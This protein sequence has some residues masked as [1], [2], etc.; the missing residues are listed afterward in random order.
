MYGDDRLGLIQQA[1]T[2]LLENLADNDY[3]SIVTYAGDCRVALDGAV[4]HG[5]TKIANVLQDL[6][7]SGSTNGSGGIQLAYE[8]AT[9]YFVEGATT[10]LFLPPT[11]TS[12]WAFP[13]KTNSNPSFPKNATAAFI[14]PCW[15]W[16]C[17][18]PTTPQ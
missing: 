9:K 15:G 12:T 8:E 13:T 3:V 10:E 6:E 5:K 4:R 2:M 7:A 17:S 14:F 1:F 16:E 11:A 18:T